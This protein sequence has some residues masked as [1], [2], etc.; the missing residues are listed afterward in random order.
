MRKNVVLT[1]KLA[2][3]GALNTIVVIVSGHATV[4]S[5]KSVRNLG[6]MDKITKFQDGL[7]LSLSVILFLS[8]SALLVNILFTETTVEKKITHAVP[9]KKMLNKPAVKPTRTIQLPPPPP[10]EVIPPKQLQVSQKTIIPLVPAPNQTKRTRHFKPLQ[11]TP[12]TTR[13][14]K[15]KRIS[16]EN[17][18]QKTEKVTRQ[19]SK[20]T[21]QSPQ[22]I[23]KSKSPASQKTSF[24]QKKD[25]ISENGRVLLR[26]L[27]NGKGPEIQIAWPNQ[28][29]LKNKIYTILNKCYGMQTARMNSRDELFN[30]N[31]LAGVRW[32]INMDKMSGFIRE[33]SG[34]T[35]SVEQTQVH[36]INR[37][38]PNENFKSTIRIFPRIVDANLLA[39]LRLLVGENY[40]NSQNINAAYGIKNNTIFIKNIKVD[41]ESLGS[42][43]QL[44]SVK[45]QCS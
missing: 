43:F 31:G 38:H 3:Q 8:V 22:K 30:A 21:K 4:R 12:G 20:K 35:P 13:A 44:P 11:V 7:A 5:L 37:K 41:G 23:L 42:D 45:S 28:S 1:R 19:V 27:E 34:S 25:N 24:L 14:E 16:P 6:L 2:A 15:E 29:N 36:L 32:A 40:S 26:Q 17:L 10:I 18:N 9:L 39:K 33:V